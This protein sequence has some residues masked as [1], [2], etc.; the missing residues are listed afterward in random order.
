M[1]TT[2]VFLLIISAA[3]VYSI[4]AIRL[5]FA[6]YDSNLRTIDYLEIYCK[7]TLVNIILPYKIGE[8]YRMYCYGHKINNYT[9]GIIIICLDRFMDTAAL[10]TMMFFWR[11]SEFLVYVMSLVLFFLMMLYWGFSE[12][13]Q[14]WNNYLLKTTVS[15]RKIKMLKRLKSLKILYKEIQFIV[16]GRGMILYF[17]SLTAWVIEVGFHNDDIVKYLYSVM[18]VS[19]S[20]FIF[21]S[22][23]ELLIVYVVLNIYKLIKKVMMYRENTGCF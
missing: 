17:L 21:V 3:L 11:N 18:K 19:S 22:I 23:I 12:I 4:K 2:D 6:L 13:Y 14:F 8:F 1:I 5:F 10:L 16:K 20:Q 15:A 9:K 7:V